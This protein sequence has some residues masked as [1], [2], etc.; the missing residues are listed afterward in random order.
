MALG[1]PTLLFEAQEWMR[2]PGVAPEDTLFGARGGGE[3]DRLAWVQGRRGQCADLR[4]VWD[5]SAGPGGR[6]GLRRG[7]PDWGGER[8]QP[9]VRGG[10]RRSGHGAGRA[11]SGLSIEASSL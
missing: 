3:R 4:C 7:W 2:G 5:L 10:A 9:A 1:R 8:D 6:A 11:A